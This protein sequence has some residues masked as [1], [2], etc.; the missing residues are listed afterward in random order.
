MIGDVGVGKRAQPEG[1]ACQENQL[2]HWKVGT[3]SSKPDLRKGRA[4]RMSSVTML[5]P[6]H[7]TKFPQSPQP[8][9]TILACEYT[10]ELG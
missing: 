8:L 4:K 10:E 5:N 6:T 7:I 3:L 2:L 1:G 9:R